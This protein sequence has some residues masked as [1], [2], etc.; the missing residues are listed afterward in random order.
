MRIILAGIVGGIAMFVWASIA[1]VA[2]PLGATGISTLPNEGETLLSLNNLIGENGG[3]YLFPSPP[4]TASQSQ[5][6]PAVGPAGL[7]VWRPRTVMALTPSNLAAEFA[8]E[9][10]ES[11]IAAFLLSWASVQGFVPRVGY[12][13]LIGAAA[14]ITTNVSYWNWYGF[15]TDYTLAYGSIEIV[16][17]VV[18]GIAIALI[19]PRRL[20]ST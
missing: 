5:E 7:L 14:A 10:A 17:Y 8:T 20:A 11:L 1:H 16:G 4:K 12:V 13:A 3:L 19:L 2:T 6:P 15:P 18:A 9:L